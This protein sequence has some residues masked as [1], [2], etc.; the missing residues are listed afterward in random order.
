MRSERLFHSLA[1]FFM[2]ADGGGI[3]R[4]VLVRPCVEVSGRRRRFQILLLSPCV[5]RL[6]HLSV[7]SLNLDGGRS[8]EVAECAA[9]GLSA[10][11]RGVEA[12]HSST[13]PRHAP[14]PHGDRPVRHL[15]EWQSS[16]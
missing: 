13:P 10:V 8:L 4:G 11:R 12:H 14:R 3:R 15:T 7:L 1:L 9:A 2:N 6:H 16:G 5:T